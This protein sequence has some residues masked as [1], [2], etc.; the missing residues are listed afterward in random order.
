[1]DPRNAPPNP[2]ARPLSETSTRDARSAPIPPPPFSLQAPVRQ[3]Q[4]TLVNDPFLPRR[5]ERDR[6]LQE[7]STVS[8]GPFS[9]GQYAAAL[10]REPSRLVTIPAEGRPRESNGSWSL[11]DRATNGYMS[12]DVRGEL[13]SS[14]CAP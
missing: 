14:T 1:M 9:L 12:Q 10:A 6:P 11:G 3:S 13:T 8:Q 2:F 5:N 7:A 4:P